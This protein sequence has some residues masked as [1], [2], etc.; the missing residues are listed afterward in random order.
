MV[1]FR[2]AGGLSTPKCY[3]SKNDRTLKWHLNFSRVICCDEH[4]CDDEH[5]KQLGIVMLWV[6]SS[7]PYSWKI[8]LKMLKI[9]FFSPWSPY[10]FCFRKRNFSSKALDSHLVRIRSPKLYYWKN[11]KPSP[12]IIVTIPPQSTVHTTRNT[13][14]FIT[15]SKIASDLLNSFS[16]SRN[17]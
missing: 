10:F 17:M 2:M 5:S 8:D 11:K 15:N 1:Y 7:S 4:R 14:N 13:W 12:R 9:R 6:Q 3:K 16:N